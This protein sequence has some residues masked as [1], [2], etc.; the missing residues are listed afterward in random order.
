MRLLLLVGRRRR[1]K[2]RLG[3]R[4]CRLSRGRRRRR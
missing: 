1:R 2:S 4:G 3:D